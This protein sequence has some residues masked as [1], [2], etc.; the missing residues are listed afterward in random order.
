MKN[1]YPIK[2]DAC[3]HDMATTF[4][5]DTNQHQGW[6]LWDSAADAAAGNSGVYPAN[7]TERVRC[8]AEHAEA[9]VEDD[10]DG[11]TTIVAAAVA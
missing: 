8:T 10:E 9:L 7:G 1:N 3:G 2:C 6:L 5:T 4:T 11:W